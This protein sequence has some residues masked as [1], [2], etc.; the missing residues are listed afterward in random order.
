MLR[1]F[2]RD[3][4]SLGWKE[5]AMTTGE[6]AQTLREAAEV[7]TALADVIEE[8]MNDDDIDA[9]MTNA[10]IDL[11]AALPGTPIC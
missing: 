9:V 8:R 6:F 2:R 3:R 5:G 11:H 1:G 4:L 10:A 7:L